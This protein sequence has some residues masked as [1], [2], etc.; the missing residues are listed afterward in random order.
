MAGGCFGF[1]GYP[2]R[3]FGLGNPR[4]TSSKVLN[5]TLPSWL[6]LLSCNGGHP[7]LLNVFFFIEPSMAMAIEADIGRD[8]WAK[9]RRFDWFFCVCLIGCS[10]PCIYGLI[11]RA[12]WEN[13]PWKEDVR[14]QQSTVDKTKGWPSATIYHIGQID[15]VHS[16]SNV[17]PLV[18]L[19]PTSSAA[20][21][22]CPRF[23]FGDGE[24]NDACPYNYNLG[25]PKK[26]HFYVIATRL[27]TCIYDT[28]QE[29]IR[30]VT[31]IPHNKS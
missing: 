3:T 24:S 10:L 11:E 26:K 22:F 13:T 21:I 12:N 28:P 29:A 25:I 20:P 31:N 15:I 2:T 7:I 18:G 30:L 5:A 17:M 23:P 14:P 8:M 1:W 6:P 9:C 27:H 19:R 4:E 16:L